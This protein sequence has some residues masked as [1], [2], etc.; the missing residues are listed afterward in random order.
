[1]LTMSVAQVCFLLLL[2][3]DQS[4]TDSLTPTLRASVFNLEI[5]RKKGF[6]ISES[7]AVGIFLNHHGLK[8]SDN[9]SFQASFVRELLNT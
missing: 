8:D 3:S 9:E 6:S 4:G 2:Q 1:M 5:P 7:E